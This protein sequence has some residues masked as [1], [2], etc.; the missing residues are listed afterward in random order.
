MNYEVKDF[1]KDVIGRSSE[2]PVLVDFWAEWCAPC[3]ILS[4]VLEKLAEK[5]KQEWEL[6]KLNTEEFPDLASRYQ[7]QSIPNVKLFSKGAVADEFVGA[8]PESRIEQ[9]LT[10]ALPDKSAEQLDLAESLIRQQKFVAASDILEPIL[11][12]SADH[13]RARALMALAL[14]FSNSKRARELVSPL[15]EASRYADAAETVRTFDTLFRKAE[16]P[17]LLV[18]GFSKRAYLDAI[19]QLSL[20]DFDRALQE[21]IGIIRSDRFYDDDGSRK[22]CV[23]IFRLLGEENDTTLKYRRDFGNSLYV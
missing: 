11:A 13:E 19:R 17:D 9:W 21:F 15:D 3:R 14:V 23:A 8:L 7:I 4:P 22:A 12:A 10:K 1:E 6:K 20:Q 16:H 18:E 2:I 5:H